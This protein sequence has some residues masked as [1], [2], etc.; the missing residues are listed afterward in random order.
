[1]WAIFVAVILTSM[2]GLSLLTRQADQP[3]PPTLQSDAL[4]V[5]MMVFDRAAVQFAI[6]HDPLN[7][8]VARTALALPGW[9]EDLGGWQTK[10]VGGV[11][12]VTYPTNPSRLTP[13]LIDAL[14]RHSDGQLLVGI[15]GG[16][17]YHA[18]PVGI[19]ICPGVATPTASCES[20]LIL[21]SVL[22]SI[23]DRTPV[24]VRKI[25]T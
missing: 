24:I 15:K 4:A 17:S 25:K 19:S 10:V 6:A 1:M 20:S 13:N 11:F 3:R 8:T 5:N 7:G 14:L 23:P 12:T 21:A 18:M 9:Y 22:A 2:L 16:A